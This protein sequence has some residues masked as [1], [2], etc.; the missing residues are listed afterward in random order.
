MRAGESENAVGSLL[1]QNGF[2]PLASLLAGEAR[3]LLVRRT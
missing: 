1:R 3:W 2:A